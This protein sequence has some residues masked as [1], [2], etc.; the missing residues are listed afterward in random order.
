[1]F[2]LDTLGRQWK[3][4][5]QVER[6]RIG[7]GVLVFL[8][9]FSLTAI[10]ANAQF[11][12]AKGGTDPIQYPE[13]SAEYA[14]LTAASKHMR[15]VDF[16]LRQ[17][18][19]KGELSAAAGKAIKLQLFPHTEYRIFLAAAPKEVP[20]GTKVHLKI[21][22]RDSK[23]VASASSKFRSMVAVAKFVPKKTGLYMIL[24]RLEAP[25]GAPADFRAPCAMFYGYE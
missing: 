16:S 23:V 18:H 25:K 10:P 19:W 20:K 8:G 21:V 15:D 1:M 24:M 5:Q 4:S 3:S 2:V 7:I 13:G 9:F 12:R 14:A 22:N 17:E 11:G 6:R